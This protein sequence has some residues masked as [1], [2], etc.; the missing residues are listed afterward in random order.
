[1]ITVTNQAKEILRDYQCPEGTVLR[2]DFVSGHH[3]HDGF[4]VRLGA[5]RPQGPDQIVEHDGKVLLR[6]ARY[7]SEEFN[8]GTIDR[9]ET[10]EGPAV[11]MTPPSPPGAPP[12]TDG[13]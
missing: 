10:L 3:Q 4:C 6:I 5:G 2:L 7:V 9:V 13:S 12:F 1:M 11:G 8:G